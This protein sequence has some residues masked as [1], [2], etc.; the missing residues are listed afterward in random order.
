MAEG[1]FNAAADTVLAAYPWI[2]MHVGAPGAAGTSNAATETTRK[3]ITWGAA[4]AG[5]ALNTNAPS[6]A[7]VAGSEDWTHFTLWSA[8]TAGT[9]GLSGTITANALVITDT[10]TIAIGALSVTVTVAS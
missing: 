7:S 10:A 5:V 1:F 8:S 4:A 2:K 9:A 6:W 3:Q